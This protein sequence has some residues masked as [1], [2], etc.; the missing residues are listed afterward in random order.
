MS[1]E[2]VW[3][4]GKKRKPHDCEVHKRCVKKLNTQIA[5]KARDILRGSSI[6]FISEIAGRDEST[7]GQ[8][9]EEILH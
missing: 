8:L 4:K 1:E 9:Q 6:E 3:K 5:H 7:I 2:A